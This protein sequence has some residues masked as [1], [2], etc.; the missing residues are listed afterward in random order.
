MGK[1]TKM[2][3]NARAHPGV[4][5]TKLQLDSSVAEA[6]SR[7]W[8]EQQ[9]P[10]RKDADGKIVATADRSMS[11]EGKLT[12]GLDGVRLLVLTLLCWGWNITDEEKPQWERLAVESVFF[13]STL[14]LFKKVLRH[15]K[16]DKARSNQRSGLGRARVLMVDERLSVRRDF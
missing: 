16:I 6:L 10:A 15:W 2:S 9:P 3:W 7:Q 8:S 4:I 14:K 13:A 1:T 5:R 12:P 11:W